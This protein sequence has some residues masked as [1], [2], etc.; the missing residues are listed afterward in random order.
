TSIG[1]GTDDSGECGLSE[2]SL[3]ATWV[4][5]FIGYKRQEVSIRGWAELNVSMQTEILDGEELVAN[6]L[7][8]ER[9]EKALGY[10]IQE[11]GVIHWLKHARIILPM[12]CREK[13]KDYWLFAGV[14]FR[15]VPQK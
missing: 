8:S 4:F 1:I 10:D 5:G 15:Q 13:W 11:V 6:A 9:E 3:Q 7:G 12:R 2:G 14:M